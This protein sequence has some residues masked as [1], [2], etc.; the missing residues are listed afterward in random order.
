MNGA[1]AFGERGG[2]GGRG[3]RETLYPVPWEPRAVGWIV[4]NQ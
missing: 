4:V 1:Y 2:K 3:D